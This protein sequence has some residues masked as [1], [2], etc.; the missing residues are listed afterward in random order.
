MLCFGNVFSTI[1]DPHATT[2][3]EKPKYEMDWVITR[4]NKIDLPVFLL[5]QWFNEPHHHVEIYRILSEILCP[6]SNENICSAG[7]ITFYNP[8]FLHRFHLKTLRA[9]FVDMITFTFNRT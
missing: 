9:N 2:S 4:K 6:F 5:M 7:I 8:I 1:L 3:L